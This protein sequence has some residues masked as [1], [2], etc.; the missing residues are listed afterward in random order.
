[1]SRLHIPDLQ[2]TSAVSFIPDST[3]EYPVHILDTIMESGPHLLMPVQENAP[4]NLAGEQPQNQILLLTGPE[5]ETQPGTRSPAT[6]EEPPA[7]P[8][9]SDT[10]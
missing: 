2:I 8:P 9:A 7:T 3:I 6:V 4:S 5:P 1:M 10:L